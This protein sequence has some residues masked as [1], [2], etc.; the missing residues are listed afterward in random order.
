MQWRWPLPSGQAFGMQGRI[1]VF[2]SG[3][4]CPVLYVTGV[5]RWLQKRATR[6]RNEALRTGS[7]KIIEHE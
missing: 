3:L 4:A 1:L 6:R 5:I 2:L 7:N